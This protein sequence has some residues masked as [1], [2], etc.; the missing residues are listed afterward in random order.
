MPKFPSKNPSFLVQLGGEKNKIFEEVLILIKD[1]KHKITFDISAS[2][3]KQRDGARPRYLGPCQIVPHRS[4]CW[5]K[6]KKKLGKQ[7][8]MSANIRHQAVLA[9]SE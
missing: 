5:R 2:Q 3:W 1:S 7:G 8:N 9:P 4:N 6:K